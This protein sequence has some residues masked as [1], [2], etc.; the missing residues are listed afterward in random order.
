MLST[1]HEGDLAGLK[2]ATLGVV[3]ILIVITNGV[4]IAV[5]ARYRDLWDDRITIFMFSLAISNF[6]SG[7]TFIPLSAFLCLSSTPSETITNKHLPKVYMFFQTLLVGSNWCSVTFVTVSKTIVILRPLRYRELLTNNRCYCVLVCSWVACLLHAIA[8]TSVSADVTWNMKMCTS[9]LPIDRKFSAVL[10]TTLLVAGIS[11]FS[12]LGYSSVRIFIVVVRAHSQIAA[13]DQS[14]GGP[15]G[16]SG[17]DAGH[18][19]RK[20]IR[21]ARNIFI[22]CVTSV[23]LTLPV[24][25]FGV[26][27]NFSNNYLDSWW[28][29]FVALTLYDTSIFVNCLLYMLLFPTIRRKTVQML[30]DLIAC[31]V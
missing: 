29:G 18:V 24:V 13:L 25:S 22:M 6:A 19:T 3:T 28:I 15:S 27:R 4:M 31:F 9:R 16:S 12:L 26:F 1:M 17:S 2:S 30:K 8:S 10:G 11:M 20:C 5:I 14:I 7:V 21:S 23:A